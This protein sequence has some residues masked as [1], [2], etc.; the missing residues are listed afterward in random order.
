MFHSKSLRAL[1]S[2]RFSLDYY[3]RIS[4]LQGSLSSTCL[5]VMLSAGMRWN[6][7]QIHRVSVLGQCCSLSLGEHGQ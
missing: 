5:L 2:E 4:R 6:E 1:G 7:L 3:W